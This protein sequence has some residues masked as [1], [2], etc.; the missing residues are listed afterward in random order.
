MLSVNAKA[1]LEKKCGNKI[2]VGDVRGVIERA[3]S[4]Q[5]KSIRK[6]TVSLH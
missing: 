3:V 6:I 5:G 2:S 1:L 4:A